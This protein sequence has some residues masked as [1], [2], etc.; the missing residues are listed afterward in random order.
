MVHNQRYVSPLKRTRK[1]LLSMAVWDF[2]VSAKEAD[3]AVGCQSV[4]PKRNLY[5]KVYIVLP[6]NVMISKKRFYFL[7]KGENIY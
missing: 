7:L 3:K 2:P 5:L 1:H 4:A 6:K